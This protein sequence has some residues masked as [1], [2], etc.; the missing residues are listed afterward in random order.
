MSWTAQA[1]AARIGQA[2]CGRVARGRAGCVSL[3][4][5]DEAPLPASSGGTAGLAGTLALVQALGDA[6]IARRCGC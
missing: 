5:L 3:L 4:A 2:R 6:G 1:L